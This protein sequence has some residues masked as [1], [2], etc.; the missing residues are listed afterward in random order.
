M[1]S[2]RG[3]GL[4]INVII[5]AVIALIVLVVLIAIL[6]GKLGAFGKGAEEAATCDRACSTLGSKAIPPFQNAEKSSCTGNNKFLGDSFNDAS[7][8]CCCIFS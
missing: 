8:G 7:V 1:F 6:T 2:K 3:Q 4:S 5:S